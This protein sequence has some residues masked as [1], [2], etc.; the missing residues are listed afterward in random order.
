MDDL[1]TFIFLKENSQHCESLDAIL[2]ELS[3]ISFCSCK[4]LVVD[5]LLRGRLPLSLFL[6]S[7]GVCS[8]IC[9]LNN[10]EFMVT[11]CHVAGI[12]SCSY[13]CSPAAVAVTHYGQA[14]VI[15]N[16]VPCV[17]VLGKFCFPTEM[18]Q[19]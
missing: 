14:P 7:A 8:R 5:A 10:G 11:D 6:P 9:V 2:A 12:Y 4:Y 16:T 13:A 18:K 15:Y 17:L 19:K 1:C 3:F